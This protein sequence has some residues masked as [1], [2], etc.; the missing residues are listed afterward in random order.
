MDHDAASQQVS[1]STSVNGDKPSNKIFDD[2]IWFH[3]NRYQL[4]AATL[5]STR[6]I[7]PK[8]HGVQ[9]H[10]RL[11]FIDPSSQNQRQE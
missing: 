4:A 11:D 8:C 3:I 2:G 9:V 5:V 10:H 7:R 1:S 6:S